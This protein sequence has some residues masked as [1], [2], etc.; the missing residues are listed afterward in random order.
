[1]EAGLQCVAPVDP[2]AFEP[3]VVLTTYFSPEPISVV[4]VS[5]K[6]SAV[7]PP[8]SGLTQ[9]PPIQHPAT[10]QEGEEEEEECL[11]DSQPICFSENP[12]LVANRKGKGRPP[13]ERILSGPPVGYGKQGQLKTWQYTKAPSTDAQR[14]DSPIRDVSYS[15]SSQPP[16]VKQHSSPAQPAAGRETRFASIH[17][18]SNATPKDNSSTK[19]GVIQPMSRMRQTAS[20]VSQDGHSSP[21]P[22]QHGPSP[23]N[24]QTSPRAPSPDTIEEFPI[25]IKQAYKAFAAVPHSLAV[26]EPPQDKF[27]QRNNVHPVQPSPESDG[28]DDVFTDE[29]EVDGGSDSVF[30]RPSLASE[31]YATLAAVP[32]LSRPTVEFKTPSPMGRNSPEQRSFRDRQKYFEIDVKQQTPDNKPKP[33]VSLVGEDDLKKMRE[34]EAKRFD[35]CARDYL[36]DEEEEEEEDLAKQVA[37]MKASG[38]VLLDGVEYK[39]ESVGGNN[40]HAATPPR[41]CATPPS[42][43]STP[44]SY[45]GTSGPSSIDGRGDS[46]RNSMEETFRLDQRPNSMTGLVPMYPGVE[47]AAPIRTAKAERRHQDRL[48][49]QSPELAIASDKE[50]SPAEKRALEAEKRAMWRAARPYGLE[51]DVRQY[52]QDLAKRLYQSRVRA[53][54]ASANTNPNPS[55]SSSSFQPRMKSLEQ[56]ALKAQ[57]V[58]AKSKENKKRSTLD[59]LV[60]SPSPAPT[61][62]PT[63]LDDISPR[64]VTSPGRLSLSE[65]KFDYRQFAAIPSSKPVYNIESPDTADNMRYIDDGSSNPG[66]FLG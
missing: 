51:E 22:F 6:M 4:P 16:S 20:P 57:M 63:P 19:P 38:K 1:M 50:L 36:L 18:T 44:P 15:P 49:M 54:Q 41:M 64:G 5:P 9:E 29:V 27:G 17:F 62:S 23:I 26:L 11:V 14:T 28:G 24:S 33:R 7:L 25:N 42:Y 12:F 13:Q 2:L 45:C 40:S 58:I 10:P 32:R 37:A 48:R 53:S 60:E 56:D 34:E 43:N 31:D 30:P 46:Q 65:K 59:Q 66:D 52:E 8:A 47:S 35:Q 21:N 55:S 61:P 3:G 39:V